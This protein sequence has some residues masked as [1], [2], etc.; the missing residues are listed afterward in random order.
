M[1]LALL[2]TP[3]RADIILLGEAQLPGDSTD[4]SGLTGKLSDGTPANRLGGLGSAIA[5]TG[6][7]NRYILVSDRGPHDGNSN[8]LCRFHT[9]QITINPRGSKPVQARLIETRLL[10][11]AEGK[12][13]VGSLKAFD[14][15]EPSRSL[16]LDPEGVRIGRTGS[17]F[18]SDEYGPSLH[19]FDRQGKHLRPL[20]IPARFLPEHPAQMP[21][22]EL[23]PKN[24]KG[25]QPNRGMEGLAISPDGN[26]LF[27]L[28]QSPLIQD[29]ALDKDKKRIGINARLLEVDL[30]TAKTREFVYQLDA[31]GVGLSEILAINDHEFLTVERDGNGGKEAQIK[32][33]Y[34]INL[35]GATDVSMVASL[36]S[37]KLPGTITPVSKHLFLDL[38]SE[39]YHLKGEAFPEKIEGIA[40][41][42]DLPDGRRL[43]LIT[44]DN[45]FVA[46]VPL[47]IF[48]FAVDRKDLPGYKAQQFSPT[49]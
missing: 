48:A 5:Y 36:P 1:A 15:R 49:R 40:F 18:L 2:P 46:T 3:V 10:T 38:L 25:R 12:N 33:I 41:G 23:P 31:P 35:Q 28:M 20:T 45:D 37:R 11:T 7:G 6:Q 16:R 14:S 42:P 27:A 24:N 32:K 47:R 19:E 39:R 26:K 29:G 8:F 44:A 21:Q 43:L 22:D 13:F 34:R 4:L 17:I 30:A 9:L